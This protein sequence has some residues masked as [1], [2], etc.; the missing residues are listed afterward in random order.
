MYLM[1]SGKVHYTLTCKNT[2]GF[3]LMFSSVSQRARGS[4]YR[5]VCNEPDFSQAAPPLAP[6]LV[7]S[8][9]Q[10]THF[11]RQCKLVSKDAFPSHPIPM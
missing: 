6:T 7:S 4:F 1:V 8:L 11:T 2:T 9:I 5:T 3:F 10:P